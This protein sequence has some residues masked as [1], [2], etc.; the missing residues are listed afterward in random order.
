MIVFPGTTLWRGQRILG[1]GPDAD[2]IE[3]GGNSPADNFSACADRSRTRVPGCL[4]LR[5][6]DRPFQGAGHSERSACVVRLVCNTV[7]VSP[8]DSTPRMAASSRTLTGV[9]PRSLSR[10][11]H[12]PAALSKGLAWVPPRGLLR[13]VEFEVFGLLPASSVLPTPP[14]DAVQNVALRQ[15]VAGGLDH[16]DLH[17]VLRMTEYG[18]VAD[19]HLSRVRITG[20]ICLLVLIL[21]VRPSVRLSENVRVAIEKCQKKK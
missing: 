7:V 11:L 13:L 1:R 14:G 6:H 4:H 9:S 8:T 16:D 10:P 21:G 2:F 17:L 19:V 12:L 20:I 5:G 18:S 15:Q 3:P